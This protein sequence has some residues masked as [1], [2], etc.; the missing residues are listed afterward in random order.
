[1]YNKNKKAL[2]QFYTTNNEYILQNMKIP[3][4]IIDIIEPFAGNGDLV[5]FIK[6]TENLKNIKY[7]IDC[8]DIEPKKDYII[9]RDTINEPPDYNNKYVITNPPYLARNK[10]ADKKLFDKYNVNDLY[11]CFIKNIIDITCLGGIIIIPLNFWSS[12]RQADIEIRKLFLEKYKIIK[13]NIFEEQ[14]FS[15]TSYTIC[16]FQF[17][18]KKQSNIPNIVEISVYPSKITIITEL[19]SKNNYMIGG[20]IYKLPL[21]NIYKITRLTNKNRDKCN[22][23]ILVKC[24]DD[25]IT[26][27]IGLSY[28]EEKDIYIDNTPN[29]SA[30]TY[31]TL[32]IEP[33]INE[34]K[35]KK[36]IESFNKYL[37]EHREKYS[38]LFLTNYRESK[39]IAR[40]RISFD[41]VYSITEYLLDRLDRL[42]SP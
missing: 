19:N 31:A 16:S 15:D 27:Q 33:I 17:E 6:N 37:R 2:G 41:L 18:V 35:Q 21:N 4:D 32:Q 13:L 23:N 39:D 28:V 40:K 8:Y 7:N 10:S 9:K 11:K 20:E 25:N 14:V 1:M 26:S 22:T 5:N 34:E 38:S 36:L 24:I 3:D 29:Q 42:E 12:I 30:R